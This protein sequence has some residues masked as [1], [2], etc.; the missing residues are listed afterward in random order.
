MI[1]HAAVHVHVPG[2]NARAEIRMRLPA[3]ANSTRADWAEIAYKKA[4]MMLDPAPE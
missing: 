3:P 1:V 2:L 4:L